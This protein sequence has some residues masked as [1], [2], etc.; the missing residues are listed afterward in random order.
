MLHP[1]RGSYRWACGRTYEHMVPALTL[2]H[3]MTPHEAST[4]RARITPARETDL[5][6]TAGRR[7]TER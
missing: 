6:G 1:P 2:D 7:K 5:L 4:W 3:I